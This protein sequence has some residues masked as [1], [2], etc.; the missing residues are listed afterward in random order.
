[1]VRLRPSARA[2]FR[3]A[4]ACCPCLS[5]RSLCCEP[6]V[7]RSLSTWLGLDPAIRLV[8]S[9]HTHHGYTCQVDGRI[10]TQGDSFGHMLT[11]IT[12]TIAPDAADLASKITAISARNVSPLQEAEVVV[13]G[14]PAGR[15]CCGDEVR[16]VAGSQRA[17]LMVQSEGSFYQ[18]VEA[19][20]FDRRD[21][22]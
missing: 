2:G 5:R 17:R 13:D 15:L 10:V 19:K 20:L 16:I 14:E 8:I 21:A 4:R 1:M 6:L 9:A 12:L 11:R 3:S 18:N 7:F 22:R